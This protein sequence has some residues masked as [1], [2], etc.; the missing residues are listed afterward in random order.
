M[1]TT[2]PQ[3]RVRYAAAVPQQCFVVVAFVAAILVVA[4]LVVAIILALAVLVVLAVVIHLLLLLMLI[5][6][7]RQTC[8]L[9]L[10]GS[11]FPV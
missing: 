6:M 2:A 9:R 11:R 8:I 1:T 7:S 4:I 5:G 3:R 10:Y